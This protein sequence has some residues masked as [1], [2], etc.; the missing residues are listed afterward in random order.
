MLLLVGVVIVLWDRG[1][2]VA[3]PV[4]V[5]LYG[6]YRCYSLGLLIF[7]D[8][9]V[10]RNPLRTYVLPLRPELLFRLGFI[11]AIY[12]A[13][14]GVEIAWYGGKVSIVATGGLAETERLRLFQQLQELVES[15]RVQSQVPPT[16]KSAW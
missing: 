9:V 14:P 11:T 13:V 15:G 10:I 16:W 12:P 2:I 5:I 7:D 8:R 3:A 4:L 1:P 6:L